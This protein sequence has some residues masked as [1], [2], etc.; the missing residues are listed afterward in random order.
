MPAPTGRRSWHVKSRAEPSC[1][2][3][4]AKERHE[5]HVATSGAKQPVVCELLQPL[6]RA[7]R[8]LSESFVARPGFSRQETI[9][10]HNL[11]SPDRL[12]RALTGIAMLAGAFMAPVP[13][14]V[15]VLVFGAMG[16]YLLITAVSGICF[17]Y[18]VLHKSTCPLHPKGGAP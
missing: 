8:R 14:P 4:P 3:Y 2:P 15:R 12:L 1:I 18:S 13:L 16:V 7:Q 6:P 11:G 5:I 9:M 10:K 17:G